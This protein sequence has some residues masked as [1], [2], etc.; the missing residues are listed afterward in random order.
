MSQI[1]YIIYLLSV[2][3]IV[4]LLARKWTWIDRV[5]PM[6]VLYIIG[7]LVANITPWLADESLLSL[8]N[9]VGNL[10]I[11]MA[12]P[13]MLISCRLSGWSLG[14]TIKAFLI[15]LGSV[16]TITIAGFFLFQS[17]GNHEQFA[18]ICA[19]AIGIYTGGIPNMGAIA[20]GVHMDQATYLYVTSYDLI[21]TG[22]YLVFVICFGRPVF[23]FLLPASKP[24]A[25]A[26]LPQKTNDTPLRHYSILQQI[27]IPASLTLAIAGISYYVSTLFSESLSTPVLILMLTTLSIGCSFLPWCQQINIQADAEKR[28]AHSFTLGLYFVYLFCFSIANACNVRTMDLTGSLPILWYILFIIFGSLV[29]QII[30]SRLFRVDA[31]TTLVSSVALINSPPFVPLVA[32]LLNNKDLIIVGI[33]IGL[34]GYMLGNYLGLAIFFIL[35]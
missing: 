28:Q 13:L 10:G 31:D 27:I 15:G 14:R 16:L 11:P 7:L 5:S 4:M 20:Q 22:L 17:L 1:L 29:L 18:Q 12:I 35:T 32:A 9:F 3:A 6:A 23:R 2:P 25:S 24:Q 34:L 26:T 21:I 19:V 8:N 30:L 33:T